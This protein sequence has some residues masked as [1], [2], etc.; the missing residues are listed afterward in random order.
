MGRISARMPAGVLVGDQRKDQLLLLQDLTGDG[1][2]NDP[3]ETRV[4]FDASNLSG[5]VDPTRNI[6][7]VHQGSDGAVYAGD[8]ST[9]TVYRLMDE[10][11]DGDANDP[12]EAKTWFSAA[13]AAGFS[14]V[15][16][17]G[18]HEGQDGA[19]YIVNAGTG[20][21]PQDAI[22]RTEDLNGDGDA[23]DAGEA[24][25]WIDLQSLNISSSAFDLSFSGSVAYVSDTVGGDTDVIYRLEDENGDGMISADEAG[26]FIS[27][28]MSFGAPVDISNAV[29]PDGSLYTLSWFPETNAISRLYRLTDL[30]ASGK[31]DDAAEVIEVWNATALPDGFDIFVGFSVAAD[32]DGR[33]VI[34]ADGN[35]ATLTDQTGDGDFLDAGETVIL[36]SDQFDDQLDRPRAVEFYEGAPA[37]APTTLGA[38][39]H[40]SVFL[41]T[42]NNTLYSTGENVVAQLG[43]GA[44]GFD[45]KTPL[46]VEL[47]DGF[48]DTIVSVSAGLIHTTFLTDKGDVYSFGFNNR[49]PLGLGDEEP[50]TIA[51][52]IEGAFGGEKVVGIDNGN[53]VSHAITESG[54]LY[55]WG[56]N[57]NGQLGL[58]D[59]DERLIPTLVEALA[60]ETIVT[61]SSGVSFTLV[62]TADGQVWGFGANRDGQLGSPDAVD[63][64]GDP[65]TRVIE[66]VLVDGL[67]HDIVALTADGNTSYAVTSDGRVFGWGEGNF[68][69]LLKGTDNG[70]GTFVP[71][72]ENVLVP[73]ELTALPPDVVDVK[74]GARWGAALTADGDV[75]T[76][77]PND[78]GPTGGLDGDPGLESNVSF[79]P[80]KIAELDDVNIVELQTGPNSLLAVDDTGQIYSWGS[81]S[82]GRLGYASE[83][84]VYFPQPVEL[85]GEAPPWLVSAEPSDNGRDVETDA[86]L[87]LG[88]T[89]EVEAGDGSVRV[90]NRDTGQVTEINI[91]DERLVKFDGTTVVIT[92]PEHFSTDTRY[93]VEIVDGAIVDSSGTSYAGIAAGDTSTFN[94]TTAEIPA[95]STGSL[96]GGFRDD[97]RRGGSDDDFV[98]GRFGD[99]IISGGEGDDRLNGGFG[100]DLVLGGTGDDRGNGG[101]GDDALYGG[102]G[103]DRL[104]GGLGHDELSGG[105]GNDILT[106][107]LGRD[108]FVFDRGSDMVKDFSPGFEFL[109]FKLPGDRLRVDV[110]GFEDAE[111]I[112]AVAEQDGRDVVFRFDE[113]TELT[114][115]RTNLRDLDAGDFVFI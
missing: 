6:F 102:D 98:S 4:F 14:T 70:D 47:P 110:D 36:G 81:N 34:T 38:G 76:W 83:G 108:V 92:P 91:A 100:D 105:A 1:D 13:N 35:V 66:P 111:A 78:E 69:Q 99:D 32:E 3:E 8:G 96:R 62:L 79:F 88:F 44:I 80:T 95:A 59:R 41:D 52:Q 77:G 23:D 115:A 75:Y 51:T 18:V 90:V 27:D 64:N 73:T 82:D 67:P 7:T 103:D 61:V 25:L 112:L 2:A 29:A 106:G 9:D 101:L 33:V 22:Y 74:G 16:P 39:N 48:S 86:V 19:I 85:E 113:E 42:G 89:E 56:S 60:D 10:N 109:W 54:K 94:F 31:I 40:F 28:E 68:G 57:T 72:E 5:I 58:G 46:P 87:T 53:G 20:S 17:N 50:R 45:V 24:T 84:P 63:E 55:A 37:P 11:G 15:T 30:D 21:V 114:L 107:G 97:L 49:G 104:H 12:G 93:A 65:L 43:N 26:V 71:A